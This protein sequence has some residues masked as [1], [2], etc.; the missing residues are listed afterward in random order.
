[1]KPPSTKPSNSTQACNTLS[2]GDDQSFDDVLRENLFKEHILNPLLTLVFPC[3]TWTFSSCQ[4]GKKYASTNATN[5]P[6]V[7]N[8]FSLMLLV[9]Q[10]WW[11]FSTESRSR[12]METC[13]SNLQFNS[14]LYN[15]VRKNGDNVAF[16]A[17]GHYICWQRVLHFGGFCWSLKATDF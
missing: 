6:I 9:T 12:F 1:M 5:A 13:Q 17:D 3:I 14:M 16:T 10:M 7:V 4:E 8:Q 11:F 15:D 2:T